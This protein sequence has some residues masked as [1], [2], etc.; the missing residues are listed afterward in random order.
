MVGSAICRKRKSARKALAYQHATAAS[1]PLRS[2]WPTTEERVD[3][4]VKFD[5]VLTK[6]K[7]VKC[8]EMA[9]VN[10]S[11]CWS[12]HDEGGAHDDFTR[13][14]TARKMNFA[15]HISTGHI[16]V[17]YHIH[18]CKLFW[19]KQVNGMQNKHSLLQSV[20]SSIHQ[21]LTEAAKARFMTQV[22][23]RDGICCETHP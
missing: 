14:F 18:S 19:A 12:F 22:T 16:S 1:N 7:M 17:Y 15:W 5:S 9:T 8:G 21:W 2:L 11:S 4:C 3:T 10:R 23:N 6:K 13:D 20:I